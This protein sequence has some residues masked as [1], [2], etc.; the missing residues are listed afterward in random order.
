MV[1]FLYMIGLFMLSFLVFL[2]VSIKC[3]F[4][5]LGGVIGGKFMIL[6]WF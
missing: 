6:K 1:N 4:L 2:F 3:N 5:V